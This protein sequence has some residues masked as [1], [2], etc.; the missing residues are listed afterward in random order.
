MEGTYD[1]MLG[2]EK[3]GTVTV[4]GQGLYWVIRC[5]CGLYSDVMQDLVATAGDRQLRI[6][7]LTPEG[8]KYGLHKRIPKKELQSVDG[9]SLCPRHGRMDGQFFSISPQEPFG[10]LSR[11]EEAYLCRREGKTGLLLPRKK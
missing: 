5:T 1:V 4:T 9:F 11:L 2:P 6:G 7:L 10:Y 3:R 8:T